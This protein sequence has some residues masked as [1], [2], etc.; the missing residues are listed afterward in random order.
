MTNEKLKEILIKHNKWILGEEAGER[1]DLSGANLWKANLRGVNLYGADMSGVNLYEAN[2]SEANLCEAN[3]S[4]ADLCGANLCETNMY[5]AN[6]CE[7]DLRG[8]NLYEANLYKANLCKANL[9]GADLYGANLRGANMY[10]A[11][12]CETNM[13]G[14]NMYETDILDYQYPIA[15]PEEGSFIGF[16]KAIVGNID[17]IVK[18]LITENAYRCSATTRKCRC[19]EAKVLSIESIDGKATYKTAN[20][21]FNNNFI[22]EV[23]EIVKIDDFEKNRWDECS[24]GIHFFITREEAVRY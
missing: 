17:V 14:A 4:E 18:L 13:R 2:L 24:R 7:A 11:N 10:E 16:K 22:Y 9:Y 15:C 19:S 12:L 6:L 20:S 5:G 8:A 3:L 1:A 21:K 23:G